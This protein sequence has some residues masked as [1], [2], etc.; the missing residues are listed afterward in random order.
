M[1][2]PI[3][4]DVNDSFYNQAVQNLLMQHGKSVIFEF[5][6]KA[7]E[8]NSVSENNEDFFPCWYFLFFEK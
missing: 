5:E 3:N 4:G 8:I 2:T 1:K 7:F 6:F